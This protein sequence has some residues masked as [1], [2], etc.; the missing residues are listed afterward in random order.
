VIALAVALR[1]EWT[2]GSRF[3]MSHDKIREAARERMARTGESYAAAR[4]AVIGQHRAADSA[5]QPPGARWFAISYS[6]TWT[7]RLTNSLDRILFRADRG[8]SGVEVGERQI[9]VRMGSFKLDLPRA[10]VRSVRRSDAKVGGTAGVHGQRG[11]WLVNGSAQGLVELAIDPPGRISASLDTL[12]GLGPSMVRQ[13]TVSLEDPDGFIAAVAG[14]RL[15][16]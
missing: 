12:F 15:A 8:I 9:R 13:L 4:R 5:G 2:T 3:T 7:G 11:R 10:S 14:D 1:R 16:G 6:D